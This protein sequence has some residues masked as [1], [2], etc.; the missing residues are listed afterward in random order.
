MR[1]TTD[2]ALQ[3]L[4]SWMYPASHPTPSDVARLAR[5]NT[6]AT[7][8]A[9]L[10]SILDRMVC[11]GTSFKTAVEQYPVPLDYPHFVSWVLRDE[12]RRDRYYEAQTAAAEVIADQMISIADAEDAVEDVARSALKIQTRKWLLGVWNRKRFGDVKQIEQNVTIDMGQAMAEAQ[13][14]AA[15]IRGDV[16]DVT[17]KELPH[18]P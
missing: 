8:E 13:E 12:V 15:R 6:L 11:E 2:Q 9:A 5:E 1:V 7:Y 3:P 10:P 17:P 18:V 14:R 4:P 16:I